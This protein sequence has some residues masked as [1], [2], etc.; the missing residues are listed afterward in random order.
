MN[1]SVNTKAYQQA[2]KAYQQASDDNLTPLQIVVELYKGILKN[3]RAAKM[4]YSAGDFQKVVDLNN[5]TFNIL[6]A[7]QANLDFDNGGDDATF[8]R[9]FYTIIF[10]KM[11]NILQQANPAA[12]YD[13]LINYINPVYER[14][15]SFAYGSVPG[16]AK[17]VEKPPA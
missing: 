9:D 13:A 16:A 4:A 8:L 6:E 5:K 17:D 12:E 1:D 2:S 14:W 11:A 3:M 10:V 7:L 15:Y